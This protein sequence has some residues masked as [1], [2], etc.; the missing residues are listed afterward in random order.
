MRGKWVVVVW[1]M[2]MIM[3]RMAGRKGMEWNGVV[4]SSSHGRREG[5][6]MLALLFAFD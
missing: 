1:L 6:I 3:T 5:D 2:I 4:A